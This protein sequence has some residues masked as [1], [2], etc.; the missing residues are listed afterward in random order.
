VDLGSGKVVGACVLAAVTAV[1]VGLGGV[2][3]WPAARGSRSRIGSGTFCGAIQQDR[4]IA[5][6]RHGHSYSDNCGAQAERCRQA[7][8]TVTFKSTG[9][10]PGMAFVLV[11]HT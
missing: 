4:S 7:C 1:V 6:A 10:P 9:L 5:S 8:T 2:L 3:R 11:S